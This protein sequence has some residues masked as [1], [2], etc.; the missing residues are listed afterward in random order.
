VQVIIAEP[1]V[2]VGGA[3][4]GVQAQILCVVGDGATKVLAVIA[5]AGTVKVGYVVVGIEGNGARI[6]R[7]RAG[8]IAAIELDGPAPGVVGGAERPGATLA[9]RRPRGRGCD[10]ADGV[11]CPGAAQQQTGCSPIEYCPRHQPLHNRCLSRRN[12][13]QPVSLPNRVYS[14][15]PITGTS[16]N[17]PTG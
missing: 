8:V 9:A 11:G 15:W 12:P 7:Y 3:V 2:V 14:L 16:H 13:G 6:I 10:I 17:P 5:G 1:A 4:A